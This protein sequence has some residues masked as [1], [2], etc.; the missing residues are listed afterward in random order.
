MPPATTNDTE[1]METDDV[2]QEAEN[3]NAT[4]EAVP[5]MQYGQAAS[6]FATGSALQRSISQ[7]GSTVSLK[8]FP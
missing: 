3:A 7:V 5:E 6:N 2:V 4:P 1:A 8:M